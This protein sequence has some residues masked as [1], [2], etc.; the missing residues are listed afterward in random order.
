M[1]AAEEAAVKRSA[2]NGWLL[3]APALVL[4]FIAASGPL[5]I[6]AIYS[7]LAPGKYGNVVWD[8]STEGWT[9]IL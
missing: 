2:R 1:S 6:V 5:I 7:F 4:L 9:G 8:F 3:S